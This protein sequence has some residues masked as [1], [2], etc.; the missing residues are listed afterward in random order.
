MCVC[1]CACCVCIACVCVCV[2]CVCVYFLPELDPKPC[3][4]GDHS[5]NTHVIFMKICCDQTNLIDQINYVQAVTFVYGAEAELEL[6]LFQ[7]VNSGNEAC[8]V[9][10]QFRAPQNI[11]GL[12]QI[13]SKCSSFAITLPSTQ[14]HYCCIPLFVLSRKNNGKIALYLLA[15][16]YSYFIIQL[17]FT[18]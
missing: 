7:C 1:V 15:Y 6:L 14:Y 3:L 17:Y 13:Y 8:T 11:L 5:L 2:W 4:V 10:R 18:K 12:R 16:V 9:V